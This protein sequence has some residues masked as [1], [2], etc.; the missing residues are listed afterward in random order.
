MSSCTLQYLGM[1]NSSIHRVLLMLS[2]VPFTELSRW[3]QSL[4]WNGIT[5]LSEPAGLNKDE[6]DSCGLD[7]SRNPLHAQHLQHSF[8]SRLERFFLIF[9]SMDREK[10]ELSF[11]TLLSSVYP[12]LREGSMNRGFRFHDNR[13]VLWSLFT[14]EECCCANLR[15]APS[16][17]AGNGKGHC[18]HIRLRFVQCVCGFP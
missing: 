14:N 11:R 16:D 13:A 5:A 15:C 6:S 7:T 4:S 10:G 3:I 9:I 17:R 12:L 2:S 18:C 1:S 8:R